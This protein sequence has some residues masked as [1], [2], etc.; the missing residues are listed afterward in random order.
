M[1]LPTLR[2]YQ[3]DVIDRARARLAYG[4]RRVIIQAPTGAGK[5]H[6][7]SEMVRRAWWMG[8]PCLFLASRR[9]LIEQKSERLTQFGVPHGVIMRGIDPTPAL[10]QVAS[11]DTLL[12]RAVR[13][14]WIDLPPAKLVIVDECHNC[15]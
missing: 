11:R 9:R 4:L 13:N 12:S 15:I 8:S 2:D 3:L 14:D 7:S 10:V 5:T 1:P 6:V